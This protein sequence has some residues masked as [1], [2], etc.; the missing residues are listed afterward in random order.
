MAKHAG[1]RGL[2]EQIEFS[3][4]ALFAIQHFELQAST[5]LIVWQLDKGLVAPHAQAFLHTAA[6]SVSLRPPL[7]RS[8][9]HAR[10]GSVVKATIP[11]DGKTT[12]L[13]RLVAASLPISRHDEC[14]PAREQ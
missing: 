7:H 8:T 11:L 6:G 10:H 9:T 13:R 4:T 2:E 1:D 3:P 5:R 14:V 12:V